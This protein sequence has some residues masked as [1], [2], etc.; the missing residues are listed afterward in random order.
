[1]RVVGIRLLA[2]LPRPDR[3]PRRVHFF[4]GSEL[5]VRSEAWRARHTV[6]MN[7]TRPD[8]TRDSRQATSGGPATSLP[9]NRQNTANVRLM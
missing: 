5:L 7:L 8:A 6:Q 3:D 4:A 2:Q 1:M 9:V